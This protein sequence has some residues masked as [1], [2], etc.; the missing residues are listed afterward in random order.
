MDGE[1]ITNRSVEK[2]KFQSRNLNE[3]DNF[4]DLGK[5]GEAMDVLEMGC[6]VMR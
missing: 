2:H 5:R 3:R 1:G 4:V 6:V